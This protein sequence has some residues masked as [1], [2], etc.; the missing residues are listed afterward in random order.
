MKTN[1]FISVLVIVLSILVLS[2]CATA[3]KKVDGDK[4][5]SLWTDDAQA[6]KELISYMDAITDPNSPDYIPVN[7]R[8]AVF[9]FDGTLFCET[10]LDYFD[11]SLLVYRVTVDEEYKSQASDFE[12]QVANEIIEKSQT[13][14][15][16]GG[17]DVPHGQAV[18]SAFKGMTP[19]QFIDYIQIFKKTAMPHYSGMNR[20]DGFYLPMLEVVNYLIDNDFTV[21][22]VTGTDRYILRGIFYDSP[23]SFIPPA[24]IIGSEQSLVV[25]SQGDPNGLEYTFKADD[26]VVFGGEFLVKNLKTNKVFIIVKE[27][28]LQPVLSFGNSSGDASMHEYTINNNP[29]RSLAFMLCCDDLDRENGNEKK[30]NDMYSQCA[31]FGWVPISM[32]NDWTTIYGD[33]VTYIKK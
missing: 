1:R 7:R 3:V 21:F 14:S 33:N 19:Q 30:A 8:I 2:S 29:Y 16:V 23:L 13:S 5:L 6:K 25:E 4:A 15:P 22:I 32:K 20:G 10:D 31:E 28:G 9:D 18:A 26:T 17:L 11:H 24:Q 12:K 27:I